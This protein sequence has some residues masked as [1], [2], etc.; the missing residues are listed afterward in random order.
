MGRE[1]AGLPPAVESGFLSILTGPWERLRSHRAGP[2]LGWL[3]TKR[4]PQQPCH[5]QRKQGSTLQ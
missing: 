5:E 3:R 1:L 4:S 2:G